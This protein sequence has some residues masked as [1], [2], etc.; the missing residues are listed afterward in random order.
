MDTVQQKSIW[1]HID[2]FEALTRFNDTCGDMDAGGHDVPK[3]AMKRLYE[4]GV[5]RSVGFG[6]SQ[7]TAFGNYVLNC[8]SEE[9]VLPLVTYGD[10]DAQWR[11]NANA[12]LKAGLAQ[13]SQIENVTL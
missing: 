2:D 4:L 3:D 11:V 6:R 10:A 8:A 9:P 12:Q 1:L 13:G 7:M 5:T